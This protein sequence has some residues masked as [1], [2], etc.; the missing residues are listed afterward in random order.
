MT[1]TEIEVFRITPEVGEK[2]YDYVENARIV[3]DYPNRRYFTN[4]QPLYLGKLNRIEEEGYGDNGYNIYHFQD[5]KIIEDF[6]GTVCF[7]HV[8]CSATGG[9]SMTH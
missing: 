4:V 9:K 8:S 2:C 1:E 7:R 6:Y 5:D 3:G